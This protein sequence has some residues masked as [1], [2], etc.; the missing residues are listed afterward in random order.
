M[1]I[2]YTHIIEEHIATPTNIDKGD[3]DFVGVLLSL[4]GT[5]K[6]NDSD[7]VVVLSEMIFR[8][9]DIVTILV[10]QERHTR[11]KIKEST[12]TKNNKNIWRNNQQLC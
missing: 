3:S 11:N 9:T 4:Q 1:T 6:H 10:A 5:K 12:S 8:G 7:M 2:I